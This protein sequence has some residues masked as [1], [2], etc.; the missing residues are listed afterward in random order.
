MNQDLYLYIQRQ[1]ARGVL[2]EDIRA[3]LVEAGWGKADIEQAFSALSVRTPSLTRPLLVPHEESHVSKKT[4]KAFFFLVALLTLLLA[5]GSISFLYLRQQSPETVLANMMERLAFVDT[6]S[7]EA[8]IV[9]SG[10]LCVEK[11]GVDSSTN[12]SPCS[13][14]KNFVNTT[15]LVGESDIT[16]SDL[17]VHQVAVVIDNSMQDEMN[18]Q[19][20]TSVQF[21]LLS[22]NK[23]LYLKL[24]DLVFT[25]P[26]FFDSAPFVGMWVRVDMGEVQQLFGIDTKGVVSLLNLEKIQ[27][28]RE[29]FL[30]QELFSYT[31]SILYPFSTEDTRMISFTLDTEKQKEFASRLHTI[32]F[33]DVTPSFGLEGILGN[34]GETSVLSG[35]IEIERD[36]LLPRSVSLDYERDAS[37]GGA[38]I[39]QARFVLNIKSYNKPVSV[40]TPTASTSF[41]EALQLLAPQSTSQ[42][43]TSTSTRV[44]R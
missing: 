18:V 43:T 1:K 2:D 36:D 9:A 42:A 14:K 31:A 30:D 26:S 8:E 37:D 27:K 23:L 16:T 44:R 5:V 25:A 34:T 4:H 41:G 19:E 3:V 38:G 13:V 20:E 21:D 7:Y 33:G 32:L 15:S 24:S 17:P 39:E 29:L 40:E 12:V 22:Q 28:L 11:G 6:L 10:T 35:E